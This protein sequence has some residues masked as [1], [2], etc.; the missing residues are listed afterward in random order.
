MPFVCA[1]PIVL[2]AQVVPL[3]KFQLCAKISPWNARMKSFTNN[4]VY[5]F[6]NNNGAMLCTIMLVLVF[7]DIHI[8]LRGCCLIG[9]KINWINCKSFICVNY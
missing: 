9:N 2:V 8:G 4:G 5:L 1:A 6:Y 3:W 7:C